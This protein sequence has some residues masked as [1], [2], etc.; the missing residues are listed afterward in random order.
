MTVPA[1]ET[2]GKTET[3]WLGRATIPLRSFD[4]RGLGRIRGDQFL[5]SI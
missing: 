4:V 1:R 5:W 2:S 3:D